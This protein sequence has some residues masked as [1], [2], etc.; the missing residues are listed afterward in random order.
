MREY[1]FI[2][3]NGIYTLINTKYNNIEVFGIGHK[4]RKIALKNAKNY[5]K[6]TFSKLNVL[7]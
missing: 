3:E 7:A 4:D 5:C 6:N 1:S 2:F